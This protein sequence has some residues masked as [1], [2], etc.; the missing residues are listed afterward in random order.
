MAILHLAYAGS[1]YGRFAKLVRAY[2]Q[3]KRT[4]IHTNRIE[5]TRNPHFQFGGEKAE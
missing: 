1:E 3:F 5:A 4:V 2:D